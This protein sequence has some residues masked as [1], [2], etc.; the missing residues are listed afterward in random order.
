MRDPSRRLRWP[1]RGLGLLALAALFVASHQPLAA[2]KEK[3]DKDDPP[4]QLKSRDLALVAASGCGYLAL[5]PSELL[6]HPL[7]KQLPA[8]TRENLQEMDRELP[9]K[10]GVSPRQL[11]RLVVAFPQG[12]MQTPVV[13]LTTDK[14]LTLAALQKNLG[15]AWKEGKGDH[16]PLLRNDRGEVLQFQGETAMIL[17]REKDVGTFLDRANANRPEPTLVRGLGSAEGGAHLVVGVRPDDLVGMF[18]LRGA[19]PPP[20]MKAVPKTESKKDAPF[21]KSDGPIKGF[22]KQPS[23]PPT[24]PGGP[25][26][27][28]DPFATAALQPDHDH[29]P[30][31]PSLAEILKDV[32]PEVLPFKPLMQCKAAVFALRLGDDTATATLTLGYNK[33]DQVED[34]QASLRVGLYVL[35]E[36]LPRWWLQEVGLKKENAVEVVRALDKVVEAIRKVE[37]R[38]AGRTVEATATLPTDAATVGVLLREMEFTGFTTE[39][40]NNLKQV[41]LALHNYHDAMGALP[42]SA[43]Y[44]AQGKPLLSWRVAI[45]PYIE[46]ENLYRQ[47]K[48]DEPWDGPNNVKLLDKMPKI[49]APPASVKAEAG[50]TFLQG[51]SGPGT[52]F[53]P[54]QDRKQGPGSMGVRLFAIT[55]GTSNTAMVGESGKAVPWT[56]PEDIPCDFKTVPP[57]G[58]V[59]GSDRCLVLMGDGSVATITTRPPRQS[60]FNMVGRQDGMIF[61]ID[62]LKPGRPRPPEAP[63]PESRPVPPRP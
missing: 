35:R 29:A 21:E 33:A 48:L 25:P 6:E 1:L 39:R 59:P 62:D 43:I 56:K 18:W 46:Q 50:H 38:V 49:Y 23:P 31:R 20:A 11:R 61:S 63:E 55:D 58:C 4:V 28:G 42:G 19:A 5:S 53:D 47:F 3:I 36:V 32:P 34:A 12:G 15:S 60:F 8:R 52:I 17:G 41:G 26:P 13:L 37:V 30:E 7:T 40:A 24:G 2:Q 54:T 22:P 51:F 10:L 45:L 57:L 27:G 16:G 9:A 14:A 44:S